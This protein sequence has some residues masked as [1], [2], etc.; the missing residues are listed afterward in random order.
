MKIIVT[1]IARSG[2]SMMMQILQA[3]GI[4]IVYDI[5]KIDEHNPNGY[6]ECRDVFNSLKLAEGKAIKI[7]LPG[8]TK[9]LRH[10]LYSSNDHII[11]IQRNI[12]EV[13]E[14]QFK[15]FKVKSNIEHYNRIFNEAY[16]NFKDKK[17]LIIQH[18]DM[19][20]NPITECEKIINFTGKD[21]NLQKMVSVVDKNLYRNKSDI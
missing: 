17:L 16:E 11:W 15:I 4:P 20:N 5:I 8:N 19:I 9:Q 13:I 10:I 6:F 3:G 12:N 14:S 2:T 18:H 1:G 7:F 21:L